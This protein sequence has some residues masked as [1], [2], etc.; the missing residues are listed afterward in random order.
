MNTPCRDCG[1]RKVGCHAHC[2]KNLEFR[3]YR[4]RLNEERH[5][6]GEICGLNNAKKRFIRKKLLNQGR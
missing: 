2:E 3:A 5:R 4:E 6:R 1:D